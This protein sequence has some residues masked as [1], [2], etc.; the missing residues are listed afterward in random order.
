MN[1]QNYKNN[2]LQITQITQIRI[3]K[4][5]ICKNLRI[6]KVDYLNSSLYDEFLKTGSLRAYNSSTYAQ[7]TA[8]LPEIICSICS[9]QQ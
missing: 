7:N 6:K 4:K 2:N 1:P 3:R 9:D 8:L 5:I